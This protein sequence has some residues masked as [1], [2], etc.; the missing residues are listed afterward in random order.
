MADRAV[1]R[2][3]QPDHRPAA[4]RPATIAAMFEHFDE[5]ARSCVVVAQQEARRLGHAEVGTAH[6]LLGLAAV[7]PDLLGVPPEALRATVVA[8]QGSGP[9]PVTG[10][11][12]F[13]A[14]ATA[15]LGAAN[16]QA[17]ALG[18]T[19]I[20]P[21]HVLLALLDAGGGG[22]RALRE[23]GAIPSEVRERARA[24]AGQDPRA[25]TA[26]APLDAAV[27][28][29][30]DHGAALRGGDPVSVTLGADRFPLGDLGNPD[31]DRRLLAL[32]LVNDTRATRL[33]RAHGIDDA[34]LREALG[35]EETGP[36]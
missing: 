2:S 3:A 36:G 31:V 26:Y 32:M 27:G 25:W 17:L 9:A 4:R 13:S 14:E 20:D 8:L 18:Q 22:M 23:T 15:A 21:A 30:A 19:T 28:P 33:L 1:A 10:P 12:P 34:R 11:V 35:P 5:P 6:L 24:T 16:G 7:A 29:P